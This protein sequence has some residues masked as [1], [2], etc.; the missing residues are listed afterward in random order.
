MEF[1]RNPSGNPIGVPVEN[2]GIPVE[3]P[4]GFRLFF[5][6]GPHGHYHE[7]IEFNLKFW[8]NIVPKFEMFYEEYLKYHW[9]LKR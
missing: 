1:Q 8:E 6:L 3:L 9:S 5:L 2:A 7:K 4:P